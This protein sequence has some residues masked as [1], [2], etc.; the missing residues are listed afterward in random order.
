MRYGTNKYG[1]EA[2]FVPKEGAKDEDDGYPSFYNSFLFLFFTFYFVF[3]IIEYSLM[4]E[5]TCLRLCTTRPPICLR[6]G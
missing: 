2:V 5:D 6:S 1:G 4:L 3:I